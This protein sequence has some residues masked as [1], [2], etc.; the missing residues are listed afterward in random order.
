MDTPSERNNKVRLIRA[1]E[2]VYKLGQFPMM[3]IVSPSFDCLWVGISP[4]KE[5]L[6]KKIKA[7]L[8]ARMKQGMVAEAK[9][10][11]AVGLSYK[12]MEELGLEYRAFASLLQGKTT[13]V[14]MFENLNLEI[15]QYAKRQMTY[16]RRNKDIKWFKPP[17]KEKIA[18]LVKAWLKKG[19]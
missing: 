18:E 2:I 15:R 5:T 19:F 12:R 16:W 17:E 9:R 14:Q 3:E 11:H 1:L 4:S 7:R 10:L 8:I 13:K 6:Q